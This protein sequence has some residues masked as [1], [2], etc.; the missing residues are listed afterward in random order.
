MS[1][2]NFFAGLR[3]CLF[4]VASLLA[5]CGGGGGG[6]GGNGPPGNVGNKSLTLSTNSLSF[7]SFQNDSQGE[8]QDIRVTWTNSKVAGFV[9][10]TLPGQAVP[11]WISVESIGTTSPVTIRVRCNSVGSAPGHY[12]MTLRFVSGDASSNILAQQ[13]AQI[14]CDVLQDPTVGAAVMTWVETEGPADRTVT[15]SHD[16]RVSTSTVSADVPWVSATLAGDTITL[17]KT[18]DSATRLPGNYVGTLAHHVHA[19]DAHAHDHF[20]GRWHG[21]ARTDGSGLIEL[22]G[23]RHH[24]RG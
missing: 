21:H 24:H 4:V 18:A 8:T 16:A 2:S 6:G 23:R 3:A 13:D 17:K 12:A 7:V 14:A 19:G 22:R 1:S 9:V 11:P 15:A 5:G 10:G 20:G